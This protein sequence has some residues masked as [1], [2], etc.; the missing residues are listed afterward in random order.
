MIDALH[1]DSLEG[2]I[3]LIPQAAA[4]AAL[5]GTRQ[6]ISSMVQ[7]YFMILGYEV[8]ATDTRQAIAAGRNPRGA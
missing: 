2:H 8:N 4:Y 6:Y 3:S 5:R 7:V 1:Q